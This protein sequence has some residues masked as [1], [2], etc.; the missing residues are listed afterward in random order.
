MKR[1]EYNTYRYIMKTLHDHMKHAP[2]GHGDTLTIMTNASA[3]FKQK[4]DAEYR[5]L[6][7]HPA[8]IRV[9]THWFDDE[10]RII[11]IYGINERYTDYYGRE[12]GWESLYTAEEKERFAKALTDDWNR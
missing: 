4:L 3:E 12:Y 5:K 11:Y 1:N 8:S 2:L 9:D 7:F 6:G 10:E